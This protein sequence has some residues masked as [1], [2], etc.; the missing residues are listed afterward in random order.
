MGKWGIKVLDVN[1]SMKSYRNK[2]RREVIVLRRYCETY[3]VG[4]IK[5]FK[6][7][8]WDLNKTSFGNCCCQ[9]SSVVEAVLILMFV[10]F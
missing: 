10:D 1:Y 9:W 6:V 5:E 4:I 3:S 2:I 7:L 8:W